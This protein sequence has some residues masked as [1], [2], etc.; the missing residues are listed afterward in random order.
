MALWMVQEL[1]AVIDVTGQDPAAAPLP[2]LS[3][4]PPGWLDAT[5]RAA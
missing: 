5:D 4:T 2:P 3:D 1:S